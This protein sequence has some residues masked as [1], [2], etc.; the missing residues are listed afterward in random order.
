M[1]NIPPEIQMIIYRFA[2]QPAAELIFQ[3]IE[4]HDEHLHQMAKVNYKTHDVI[5]KD[6]DY[7]FAKY[8]HYEYICVKKK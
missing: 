2:R 1:E 5:S 6:P 3:A 7:S 4:K 8:L